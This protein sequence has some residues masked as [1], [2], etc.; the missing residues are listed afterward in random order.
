MS[1]YLAKLRLWVSARHFSFVNQEILAFARMTI[2]CNKQEIP[3]RRLE[4]YCPH[5]CNVMAGLTRHDKKL[6][7]RRRDAK[8]IISNQWFYSQHPLASLRELKIKLLLRKSGSHNMVGKPYP[9]NW[10]AWTWFSASLSKGEG[11]EF[12]KKY[13]TIILPCTKSLRALSFVIAVSS[14]LMVINILG[15][16]V[17]P[18]RWMVG[19]ACHDSE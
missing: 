17:E 4:S 2:S 14:I 7:Q 15:S 5:Q 9:N 13:T 18:A 12:L 3:A 19:Q 6:W 8:Y 10:T 16:Y 1:F 11:L